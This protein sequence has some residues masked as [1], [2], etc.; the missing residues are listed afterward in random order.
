MNCKS[1]QELVTCTPRTE[2]RRRRGVFGIP[3]YYYADIVVWEAPHGVQNPVTD[4]HNA[5]LELE[6]ELS[7]EGV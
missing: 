5:A 4:A 1:Y 2:L 3:V 6:R 7:T